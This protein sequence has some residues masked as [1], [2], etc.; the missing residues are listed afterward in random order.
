MA[1]DEASPEVTFAS[2]PCSGR[3]HAASIQFGRS[4]LTD[5]PGITALAGRA[6]GLQHA[7]SVPSVLG[8]HAG[9]MPGDLDAICTLY[10]TLAWCEAP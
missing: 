7:E 4:L 1:P 3:I 9:I 2:D 5:G 8:D 6:I 10:G